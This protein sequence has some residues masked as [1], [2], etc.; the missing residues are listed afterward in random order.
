MSVGIVELR[1]F[2]MWGGGTRRFLLGQGVGCCT[3]TLLCSGI[4]FVLL[5]YTRLS[6]LSR[7]CYAIGSFVNVVVALD[8]IGVWFPEKPPEGLSTLLQPVVDLSTSW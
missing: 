2:F 3:S 7:D 6:L 8:A 1:I 5:Y 4:F